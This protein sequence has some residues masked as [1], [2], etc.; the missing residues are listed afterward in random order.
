M[1]THILDKIVAHKRKEVE[2]RK[3]AIPFSALEQSGMMDRTC[4]SYVNALS[5][6]SSSG[7]IAEFKRKSPSVD[8]I[9]L[10]ADPKDIVKGYQEAGANAVSILTDE[11]FFGGRDEFIQSV[12][13]LHPDLPILRK[14]FIIDEYQ[15]LESKAIGADMVLLICEI[16]SKEEI[17]RFTRFAHSL[18]MEVLLELHSKSEIYKC[19]EWISI[20]GVNNR[21]LKTFTVNYERS[22]DLYDLL[23]VD[24]PKIA[25]SGLK[26]PDTCVMLYQHGFKGFLIGEQFMKHE[27]PGLAC[28][29]F[30]FDFI[31][32]RQVI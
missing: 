28:K 20:I 19:N 29:E 17:L 18:D 8:D 16:L 12:R 2:N 14:E 23:P 1:S 26:D 27:D 6:R 21:D 31:I 5:V 7:V 10:T 25:E 3:L 4:N 11:V 32:K 9:N 15:I 13:T 30:I 24:I 22:K